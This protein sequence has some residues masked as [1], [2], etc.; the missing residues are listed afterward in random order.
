MK[1]QDAEQFEQVNVFGEGNPNEAYAQYLPGGQ[2]TVN[3]L[4]FL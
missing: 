1:Y 2:F 3:R 4:I